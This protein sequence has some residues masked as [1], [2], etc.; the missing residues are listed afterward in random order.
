MWSHHAAFSALLSNFYGLPQNCRQYRLVMKTPA[1]H[2][3]CLKN[4]KYSWLNSPRTFWWKCFTHD[5]R[6][7]APLFKPRHISILLSCDLWT[8]LLSRL[9]V[10]RKAL[11]HKAAL[12]LADFCTASSE[13]L[14][15]NSEL[16]KM[17]DSNV[18]LFLE[19]RK[20]F[21]ISQQPKLSWTACM[22]FNN[23]FFKKTV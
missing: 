16:Q 8:R 23:L 21:G 7:E 1:F 18:G 3:L 20:V 19:R 12:G 14:K 9:S 5:K 2:F 22:C 4:L 13:H 15:F 17:I 11:L 10:F 6:T